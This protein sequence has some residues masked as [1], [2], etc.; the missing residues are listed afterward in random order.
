MDVYD[1]IVRAGIDHWPLVAGLLASG[2]WLFPKMLRSSLL[3][4]S[5]EVIRTIMREENAAQ[6]KLHSEELD[7]RFRLHEEEE[8]ARFREIED[9][10]FRRSRRRVSR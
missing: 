6:T 3:N 4:G 10:V 5:G 9:R 7:R 2:Y 8:D 1:Q